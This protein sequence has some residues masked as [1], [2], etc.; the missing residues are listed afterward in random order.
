M[1]GGCQVV[2]TVFGK[3]WFIYIRK[4]K[5]ISFCIGCSPKY[6]QLKVKTLLKAVCFVFFLSPFTCCFSSILS[7]H[8]TKSWAQFPVNL[9]K[10]SSWTNFSMLQHHRVDFVFSQKVLTTGFLRRPSYMSP[11]LL[12][13]KVMIQVYINLIPRD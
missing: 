11:Q 6:F 13:K 12:E 8:E 3:L 2:T 9:L 4:F 5:L 10:L 1:G 7:Q